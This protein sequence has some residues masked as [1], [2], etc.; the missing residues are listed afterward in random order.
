MCHAGA[1]PDGPLGHWTFECPSRAKFTS[2]HRNDVTGQVEELTAEASSI[3][4]R[5]E[6]AR[7]RT[8]RA[9]DTLISV[10]LAGA[11]ID[12]KR[13]QFGEVPGGAI[14]G[15][16]FPAREGECDRAMEDALGAVVAMSDQ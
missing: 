6:L 16:V 4:E 10:A 2:P 7:P 13:K 15:P 11:F 5:K 3:H 8:G 14:G 12:R 9:A 1:D